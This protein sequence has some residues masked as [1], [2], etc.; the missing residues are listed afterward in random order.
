MKKLA[1]KKNRLGF[2]LIEMLIVILIIVL[3]IAIAVPAVAAYRRDAQRTQDE[4][5]LETVRTAIEAALIRE[6]PTLEEWGQWHRSADLNYESLINANTGNKDTDDFYKQIA[7]HLGANFKGNFKFYYY[8]NSSSG[9]GNIVWLSYWRSDGATSD[10]AVMY[11]GTSWN[12]L[13]TPMYLSEVPEALA[14]IGQSLDI[15]SARPRG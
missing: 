1:L 2:T 11:Y 5:G 9:V 10:E 3:L 7:E 14:E 12:V 13:R 15:S 8:V 4:G 6:Q